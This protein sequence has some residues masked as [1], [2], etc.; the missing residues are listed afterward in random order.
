MPLELYLVKLDFEEKK[1]NNK[2]NAVS[3][4][5]AF[6]LRWASII[7]FSESSLYFNIIL[8][9]PR[10]IICHYNTDLSK[11]PRIAVRAYLKY[12]Q[13]TLWNQ[14]WWVLWTWITC[15]NGS[16]F[17]FQIIWITYS[18]ELLS[19]FLNLIYISVLCFHCTR[20][21]AWF[22]LTVRVGVPINYQY[23]TYLAI[24][25]CTECTDMVRWDVPMYHPY[26]SPIG[27]VHST[28]CPYWAVHL[29]TTNLGQ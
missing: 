19:R 23:R 10:Y 6:I 4:T 18:S 20:S 29:D 8:M 5:W 12:P 25:T 22:I 27:L 16:C 21:I 2:H 1:K 9:P 24:L 28:Y 3:L 17:S 26:R 14:P 15:W 13:F 11:L 7:S